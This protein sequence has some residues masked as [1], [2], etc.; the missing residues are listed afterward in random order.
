M[1]SV[2]GTPEVVAALC[3]GHDLPPCS[4]SAQVQDQAS[5]FWRQI[6]V[7]TLV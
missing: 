4:K 3:G 1:S 6:Y 2:V 7:Q 5:G